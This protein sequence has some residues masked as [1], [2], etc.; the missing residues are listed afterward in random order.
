ML[1]SLWARKR[2]A[3]LF[4]VQ[5]EQTL[6]KRSAAGFDKVFIVWQNLLQ[7]KSKKVKKKYFKSHFL[8][9]RSG[10]TKKNYKIKKIG[11]PQIMLGG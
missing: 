10:H 9:R 6:F 1:F 4:N 2:K 7:S 3:S 11:H 8:D 5:Q